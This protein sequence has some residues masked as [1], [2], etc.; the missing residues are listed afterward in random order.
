MGGQ[1]ILIY[2]DMTWDGASLEKFSSLTVRIISKEMIDVRK[3][4]N[5]PP[6]GSLVCLALLSYTVEVPSLYSQPWTFWLA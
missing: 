1:L 3:M 2:E 6:L 4:E 5:R